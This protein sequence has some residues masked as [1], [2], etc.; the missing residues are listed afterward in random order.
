MVDW[1][2]YGPEGQYLVPAHDILDSLLI[3]E[4][5]ANNSEKTQASAP[6]GALRRD[7]LPE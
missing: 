6:E 7:L 3:Y 1:E 5:H 4:N 2:N